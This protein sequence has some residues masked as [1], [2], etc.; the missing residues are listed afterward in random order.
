MD[1]QP[2]EPTYRR[3][4]SF[5]VLSISW[6]KIKLF[7]NRRD[8]DL[9]SILGRSSPSLT[10]EC[11][12]KVCPVCKNPDIS[13]P[14]AFKFGALCDTEGLG[15]RVVGL[16]CQKNSKFA[17]YDGESGYLEKVRLKKHIRSLKNKSKGIAL[18][19]QGTVELPKPDLQFR[20]FMNISRPS[21]KA[22]Q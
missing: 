10:P 2:D 22:S 11:Q 16:N 20:T 8:L 7:E 1:R 9:N 18:Y 4:S 15:Y 14:S 12:N 13:D 17:S 19:K 5:K 3:S 21:Y 6:L